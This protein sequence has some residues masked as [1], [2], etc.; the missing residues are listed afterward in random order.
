M[1]WFSGSCH[2][3]TT[4]LVGMASAAAAPA[5]LTVRRHPYTR[6]P[7]LPLCSSVSTVAPAL[8][9]IRR[10][11]VRSLLC[12]CA[13]APA[14]LLHRPALLLFCCSS[15]EGLKLYCSAPDLLRCSRLQALMCC[16]AMLKCSSIQGFKLYFQN[17]V[18]S[19]VQ[20]KL[21]STLVHSS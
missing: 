2:V 18:S 5:L 10:C 11:P 15:V 12:S 19:T 6:C 21:C 16:T 9:A 1:W 14:L 20:F 3:D 8:L 17:K 13:I 4:T 7:P